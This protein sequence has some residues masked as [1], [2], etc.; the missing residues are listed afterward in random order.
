MS[1]E[2]KKELVP[3][4]NKM[5]T[6]NNP[7][8]KEDEHNDDIEGYEIKEVKTDKKDKTV[9]ESRYTKDKSN[10]GLVAI[11]LGILALLLVLAML[12]GGYRYATTGSATHSSEPAAKV[13]A[14]KDSPA[15]K[16]NKLDTSRVYNLK[17]AKDS[18]NGMSITITKAQFRQDG[19][20]LWLKMDNDSGKKIHMMP[21]VNATLVDN[22]GHSYKVDSFAGDSVTSV[23]P[24]AHEEV[25]IVFEPVRADASSVTFNLDS[26]FDMKNSAWNYAIN[27][28][29]P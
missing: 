9:V 7:K 11:I 10:N 6:G 24:G 25:M 1:D 22:N 4:N 14:E 27:F 19:T 28:D 20:R 17:E 8:D 2:N 23:A 12:V 15:L 16:A 21:N 13:M 18:F 3:V 5:V 29:L 26:V